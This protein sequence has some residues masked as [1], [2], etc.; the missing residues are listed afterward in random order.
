MSALTTNNKGDAASSVPFVV[1][2]PPLYKGSMLHS[3]MM[4]SGE[5]CKAQ[6][7]WRQNRIFHQRK[8]MHYAVLGTVGISYFSSAYAC[9]K[10]G[11]WTEEWHFKR[12][13][14]K[15]SNLRILLLFDKIKKNL[16][17][18]VRIKNFWSSMHLLTWEAFWKIWRRCMAMEERCAHHRFLE[19]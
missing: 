12:R 2:A 6:C 7:A 3:T 10:K 16:L 19:K 5:G 11:G 13:I 1:S 18:R 4:A 9:C 8:S 14:R 17:W 15:T